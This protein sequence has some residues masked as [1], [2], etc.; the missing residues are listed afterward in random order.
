[1]LNLLG[2]ELIQMWKTIEIQVAQNKKTSKAD[3]EIKAKCLSMSYH[4]DPLIE[5]KESAQI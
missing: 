3:S 1:M 2:L 4:S 5:K